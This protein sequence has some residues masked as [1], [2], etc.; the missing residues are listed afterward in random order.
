MFMA[1][2]NL[3]ITDYAVSRAIMELNKCHELI[4][5]EM[6]AEHI[7]GGASTVYRSLKHLKDSNLVQVSGGS[8]RNGGYR[9]EYL[10]D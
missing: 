3:S 10:G 2:R 6:I 1:E 7:N 5:A 9:Y 4:T 8:S